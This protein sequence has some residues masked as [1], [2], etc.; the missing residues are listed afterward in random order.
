MLI[1][2]KRAA[3]EALDVRLAAG[4]ESNGQQHGQGREQ[5]QQQRP[6]AAQQLARVTLAISRMTATLVPPD[7]RRTR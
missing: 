1:V 4:A 5:D 7:H 2:S 3:R 6:A